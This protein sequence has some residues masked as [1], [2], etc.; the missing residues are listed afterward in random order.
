MDAREYGKVVT[1]GSSCLLNV[2]E[3]MDV[4]E[5]DGCDKPFS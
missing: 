3:D 1:V 4:G 5:D 2:L